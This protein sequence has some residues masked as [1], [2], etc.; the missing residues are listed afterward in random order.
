MESIVYSVF[1]SIATKII[2]NLLGIFL[3][4]NTIE[5]EAAKR[6]NLTFKAIIFRN[7]HLNESYKFK[8]KRGLSKIKTVIL[9][10]RRFLITIGR[11]NFF[12]FICSFLN[13]FLNLKN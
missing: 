12:T 5:N 4:E 2:T 11:K 3:H 8:L 7:H 9:I 13:I 1:A 6:K 10:V